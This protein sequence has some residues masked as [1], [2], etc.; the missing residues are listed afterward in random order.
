MPGILIFFTAS[1]M[2]IEGS[3]YGNNF[4]FPNDSDNTN[5]NYLIIIW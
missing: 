2:F 3:C 4:L 1:N 5:T